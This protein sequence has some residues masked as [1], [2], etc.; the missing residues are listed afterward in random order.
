MLAALA[1]TACSLEPG[2]DDVA[3]TAAVDGLTPGARVAVTVRGQP[4]LSDTFELD[5]DGLVD[6]PLLGEVDAYGL[7]PEELAAQLVAGLADGYLREPRVDVARAQARPFFILGAVQ[8]PGSYVYQPGLTVADAIAVAGGRVDADGD[9]LVV[10]T[11]AGF[12]RHARRVELST[13]LGPG[14]IIEL[15]ERRG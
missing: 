15:T 7:S 9:Y 4:D 14:D 8:R 10:V 6:F 12:E 11:P 3:P 5:E 2:S 1:L 13:E